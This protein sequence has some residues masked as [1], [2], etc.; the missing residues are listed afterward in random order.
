MRLRMSSS[1]SKWQLSIRFHFQ[2]KPL[3]NCK[4]S[5]LLISKLTQP[6][7]F[8][9]RKKVNFEKFTC[10]EIWWKKILRCFISWKN[11]V[12]KHLSPLT[13][14]VTCPFLIPT[15]FTVWMVGLLHLYNN[16]SKF[17]TSFQNVLKRIF[18]IDFLASKVFP[19]PIPSSKLK[20]MYF[21]HISANQTLT[22]IHYGHVEHYIPIQK[23]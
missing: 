4:C 11:Q 6:P 17:T 21:F 15:H 22:T 19:S 16:F 5:E 1:R 13:S 9:F 10:E 23:L 2:N 12:V 8:W 18:R 20:V 3:L 14:R 7:L